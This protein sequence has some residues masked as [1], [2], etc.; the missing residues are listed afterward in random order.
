L[1]LLNF[2]SPPTNPYTK[3]EN[4]QTR[5][6]SFGRESLDKDYVVVGSNSSELSDESVASTEIGRRYKR[7]DALCELADSKMELSHVEEAIVLYIKVLAVLQQ[8]MQYASKSPLTESELNAVLSKY[9]DRFKDTLHKLEI[10]KL[11]TRVE[12]LPAISAEKLIYDSALS[13]GREGGV[14]EMLKNFEKSSQ[15]YE[16][17]L[18]LIEQ[19]FSEA[20][21]DADKETLQNFVQ[22]FRGTYQK[23]IHDTKQRMRN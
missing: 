19:L 13:M 20:N 2:F 15:L 12:H 5:S 17:G 8:L 21:E 3:T 1:F 14:C 16:N 22:G 18:L 23:N 7:I 11:Q 6:T 10:V 4:F 9:R